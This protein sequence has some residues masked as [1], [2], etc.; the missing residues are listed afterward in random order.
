MSEESDRRR[1]ILDAA[2]EEFASKGFRGATIKSIASAARLQ[3]PALLYWYFPQGKEELLQRVLERHAPIIQAVLDPDALLERPPEEV[4]VHLGRTYLA[5]V[6]RPPVQRLVR[7]IAQ[8]ALRRPEVADM[9]GGRLLTRVLDFL[10]AYLA[11]Q[12]ERGRLR[13]H[14]VRASARAFMGML[15]PQALTH[16][17]LPALR[18]D[19]LTDDEHLRTVVEIF[20]HGLRAGT[21]DGERAVAVHRGDE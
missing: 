10:K 14:D 1:A 15:V 18:A 8:E 21:T 6:Q 3:S 4:L 7:L 16:V 11:H 17:A 13:P 20:L 2:F 12:I 5:T 19:G 9:I